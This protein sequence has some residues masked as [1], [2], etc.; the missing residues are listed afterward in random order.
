MNSRHNTI[1]SHRMSTL[2]KTALPFLLA[3]SAAVAQTPIKIG[4]MAELSGPQGAIGQ[5]QL[6]G[7]MLL[8]ERNGGKLGGV[9]AQ[10][11]KE[12]SQLKPEV[13]A[14]IVERLIDK[15]KVSVITGFTF[16]NVMMAV[17]K[18]AAEKEVFFISSNAGPSPVAGAQCSPYVFSVAK[19]NDEEAEGMGKY[20]ADKGYKHVYAMAPNYVAGKDFVGGFKRYYKEPLVD[21]VYTPLNQA[22]FS[23]ELSQLAAAKPDAVF[24]FYPGGLGINFVRQYQQAGLLGK[25]PLLTASTTDGVGLPAMK[26]TALGIISG[27]FWGPDFANPVSRQFV[28]DFERKYK[29]VPS[30][31]AAQAFDSALLLDSAIARVNGNVSDK[32]GFAAALKAG[33]FKSVRGS[34]K[35]NHNN[36]PIQD[37]YVFEV[38]RDAQ[39]RIGLKTI[40]MALKDHQDAYQASCPMR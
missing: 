20:A 17:Y 14:Q 8:V 22:D 32:K 6:D 10:V 38:A 1:G 16:S 19:Q 27:T 31:Y 18:S 7:F 35:F 40:G 25:I 39:D 21:E 15:D 36:F 2:L 30:Q 11:L 37:V 28:D 9:S 3:T 13:A 4:F 33:D 26:E 24:A 23:V 12:D 29:R 34:F 5:D